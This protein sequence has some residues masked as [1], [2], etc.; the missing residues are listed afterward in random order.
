MIKE[1][2]IKNFLYGSFYDFV[3]NISKNRRNKLLHGD[4]AVNFLNAFYKQTQK[5][6]KRFENQSSSVWEP[7]EFDSSW[8]N[9]FSEENLAQIKAMCFF[10]IVKEYKS[11]TNHY[12]EFKNQNVLDTSISKVRS[13]LDKLK[14]FE[15]IF[16]TDHTDYVFNEIFNLAIDITREVLN[17]DVYND[18]FH[19]NDIFNLTYFYHPLTRFF[20]F[21]DTKN[22]FTGNFTYWSSKCM[23]EIY[24]IGGYDEYGLSKKNDFEL[25]EEEAIELIENAIKT[26]SHIKEIKKYGFD[27]RYPNLLKD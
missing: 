4:E 8:L 14:T 27:K 21:V 16:L 19:E 20:V 2:K 5:L 15:H 22:N 26:E 6:F 10:Y 9:K 18:I 25:K 3:L 17:K 11:G 24:K 1:I 12:K 13:S 23:R 7:Y